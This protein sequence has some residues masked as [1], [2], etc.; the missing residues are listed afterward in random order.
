[1]KE[2]ISIWQAINGSGMLLFLYVICT[3]YLL[4][5]EDKKYKKILFVVFPTLWLGVLLL[6]P[7]YRVIAS[8]I[9]EDIYYRF[10]WILPISITIAYTFTKIFELLVDKLGAV[11]DKQGRS[12]T[13][14]KLFKIE[15][16]SEIVA[17]LILSCIIII[18]GDFV[19]NNWRFSKAENIYHVPNEVIEICD[20]IHIEGREVVAAFPNEFIQ[21][22]KQ[23]DP[24]IL[25][26]Y[27]R[28]ILVREWN[29]THPLFLA[30]NKEVIDA[31]QLSEELIKS[32]STYVILEGSRVIDG[33]LE[34]YGYQEDFRCGEYIIY[35]NQVS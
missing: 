10:F 17:L 14:K 3:S 21:Y 13:R 4:V 8:L 18:S 7:I 6:P 28:N 23:Y 25:P 15:I 31:K 24:T 33:D 35:K 34:D 19:Y 12:G 32:D 26:P 16:T 30:M 22:V 2:I 29:L 9:G 11:E 20:A 1:M 27:G 5:V